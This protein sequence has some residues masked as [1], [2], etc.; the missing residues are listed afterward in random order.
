MAVYIAASN[1]NASG[2]IWGTVESTVA[3][4]YLNSEAANTLLTTSYVEG[5][6][7]TPGAIT[8]DGIA[9]KVASRAA[10]PSG[11]ISV[12]L[13][14]A[15]AT[16]AGTEVTL[17][18]SDIAFGEGLSPVSVYNG[19][20]FFKFAAPVLLVVATAYTVSAKTS[21]ANQ[22]HLYR[23]ATAGNWS[24]MVR[25][26]TLSTPG[27]GDTFHVLG[28]WTAAATSTARSVTWDITA[29]TDFGDTSTTIAS[30]TVGQGG[31]LTYGTAAAT[32]YLMRLSGIFDVCVGGVLNL[33]TTGTKCPADSSMVLEFDCAAD[34]DFGLRTFGTFLGQ[35]PERLAGVTN[36]FA[37][38]N[39]DE[40]AGQTSL[41]VDR[42]L[43]ALNGDTI[44][45]ASTTRTAADA[46]TTT[47]SADAGA[48]SLTCVAIANAHSGT[49][50]TQAEV[51]SLNR[52][53]VIRS[54]SSSFMAYVYF[55]PTA[56]V[57]CD[58][59]WFRYLGHTV[60]NKRGVEVGVTTGN[61]SLHKCAFSDFDNHGVYALGASLD[62]FSLTDCVFSKVGHQN[63]GHAA[64]RINDGTTG[65]WTISGNVVIS[66]NTG[67]GRG[68][69]LGD[70][71]GTCTDNRISSGGGEGLAFSSTS[72]FITG[73]ISGNIIHSMGLRGLTFEISPQGGTISNTTIWRTNSSGIRNTVDVLGVVFDGLTVFGCASQTWE[74]TADLVGV[75]LRN[76]SSNGDSTFATTNGLSWSTA[77]VIGLR[78]ENSAMSVAG[79]ILVA[80]T[81]DFNVSNSSYAEITTVDTTL[82]AATEVNGSS[83]LRG[84]SFIA[85]Q[86]RDGA[87]GTNL[88]TYFNVGVVSYDSVTFRTATPSE[89]L[90]PS[91]A[92]VKLTTGVKRVPA[93]SG[94]TVNISAYVNKGG[95][96]NGASPRLR[97]K[98]NAAAGVAEAT[99]ATHAAAAGSFSQLSGSVGPVAE[100]SVLEFYVDA[101]GT[102]GQVNVDDWSYTAA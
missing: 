18:V 82:S 97:V 76:F 36:H 39:T 5:V 42:Q 32:N 13:A 20:M 102:V 56:V 88:K 33:G 98:D 92:A 46:E 86:K 24:R 16:V 61:V 96:Y 9:V 66:D 93:A 80:H 78:L 62:N 72:E 65:D 4:G 10:A 30:V 75:T 67:Q 53:V 59:V 31:T 95:T 29:A 21:T 44:A 89:K 91:N 73:T 1:G 54:V 7:F 19:W 2:N 50:P 37:L 77:K 68:I 41:G 40:A 15:G 22:V 100:D 23:N 57:D 81:N 79:G 63:T 35:A 83:N 47:L 34:G 64:I 45:I 26:T 60:A 3:N 71:G 85:H 27:A 17:N 6:A 99:V 43:S 28:E 12:R 48:S 52:H 49:S 38:L 101:D 74:V 87:S 55:G 58:W 14:Q 84:R 11:T 8:I 90:E 25:T 51:I 70:F 69:D 94:Q